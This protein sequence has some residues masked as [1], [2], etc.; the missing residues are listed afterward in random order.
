M[1]KAHT[2]LE[3]SYSPNQ[4]LRKIHLHVVY[5]YFFHSLI[6]WCVC[7]LGNVIRL[8]F[9]IPLKYT[10]IEKTTHWL[11]TFSTIL[12]E[13]NSNPESIHRSKYLTIIVG[14]EDRSW[15]GL[16]ILFSKCSGLVSALWEADA[17][18]SIREQGVGWYPGNQEV[19]EQGEGRQPMKGVGTGDSAALDEFSCT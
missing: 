1:T 8:C 3:V 19:K 7:V 6:F 2:V 4:Q 16:T 18:S 10:E 11:G 17:E 5:W 14:P 15:Y 12:D 9:I 13:S